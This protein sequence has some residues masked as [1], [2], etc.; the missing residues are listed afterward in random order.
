[1]FY[2]LESTMM[3]QNDWMLLQVDKEFQSFTEDLKQIANDIYKLS[4]VHNV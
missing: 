2:S 3:L 4:Y 1:M